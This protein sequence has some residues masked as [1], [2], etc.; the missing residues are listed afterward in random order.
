MCDLCDVRS[1]CS[2]N[3]EFQGS[4]IAALKCLTENGG[5][6]TYVALEYVREYFGVR[7]GLF[8]YH[9]KECL[10]SPFRD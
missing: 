10:K 2:Y 9:F 1:R 3:D 7:M 6:V 8:M 5:D 4:H